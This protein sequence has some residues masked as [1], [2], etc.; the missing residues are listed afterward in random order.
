MASLAGAIIDYNCSEGLKARWRYKESELE[1]KVL[2]LAHALL[3]PAPAIF[4]KLVEPTITLSRRLPE[5]STRR[6]KKLGTTVNLKPRIVRLRT[7]R[8]RLRLPLKS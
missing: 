5:N 1:V 6:R 3:R 8:S 4:S 7:S 2:I